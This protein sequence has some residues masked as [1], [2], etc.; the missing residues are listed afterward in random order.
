MNTRFSLKADTYEQNA[1]VQKLSAEKL[2]D[3]LQEMISSPTIAADLGCGTGYLTQ[4]LL[5][6]FSSLKIDCC[7]ISETMLEH[8]A[9]IDNQNLCFHNCS[10]PPNANYDLIVANFSFQWFPSIEAT[11][12]H[13]FQKLKVNGTLAFSIPVKGTFKELNQLISKHKLSVKLPELPDSQD[14][15]SIVNEFENIE[16]EQFQLKESF[17]NTLEFLRGL[18]NIGAVREGQKTSISDLKSLI[19][20]HDQLFNKDIIANY[21]VLQVLIKRTTHA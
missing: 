7:D 5:K 20:L 19:T 1:L 21:E 6:K 14:I 10:I 15:L 17:A 12:K 13:S 9:K 16:V 2:A 18:H 3:K 4:Q 11:I 8:T